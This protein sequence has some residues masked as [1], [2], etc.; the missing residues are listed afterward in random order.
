[1]QWLQNFVLSRLFA[2]LSV[3]LIIFCIISLLILEPNHPLYIFSL[4]CG[5]IIFGLQIYGKYLRKQ[6]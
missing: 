6:I 5:L 3:F 4:A 2:F 1:M